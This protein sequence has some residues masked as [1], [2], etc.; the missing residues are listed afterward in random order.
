MNDEARVDAYI[1]KHEQWQAQFNSLR[2][3]LRG[4]DLEET[5]KWGAPSYT[6]DG[7]IVVGMVGFKNHCALWFQQGVFLKDEAGKLV[8]AQK[9]T[10]RGM[11]QCYCRLRGMDSLHETH[12][13]RCCCG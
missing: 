1:K 6:L 3:I 4:T 12:A 8:N 5:I 7:R 10:T 11:R 2:K 9:G 13:P